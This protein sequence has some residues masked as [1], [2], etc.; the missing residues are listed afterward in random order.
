MFKHFPCIHCLNSVPTQIH[1]GLLV[2]A[3]DPNTSN[4]RRC[5]YVIRY[6]PTCAYPIQV[7]ISLSLQNDDIPHACSYRHFA[8]KSINMCAFLTG[9]WEAQEFSWHSAGQ[10]FW[11][12][13]PFLQQNLQTV[14]GLYWTL[15]L[16][17]GCFGTNSTLTVCFPSNRT[18]YY[19]FN[20]IFLPCIYYYFYY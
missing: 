2:H 19:T 14:T 17:H 8:V 1:D 16:R 3:S 9:P 6:V 4:R 15:Y 7:K 10:R 20:I 11:Q 13:Q 18:L 5:G 12:I